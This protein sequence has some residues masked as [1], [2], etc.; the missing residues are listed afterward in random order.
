MYSNGS[1]SYL[2]SNYLKINFSFYSNYFAKII[3]KHRKLYTIFLLKEF[4]ILGLKWYTFA[5]NNGIL[6]EFCLA[7][8]MASEF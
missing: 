4:S 5:L 1:A 2:F 7:Q 6:T 8:Q 3:R